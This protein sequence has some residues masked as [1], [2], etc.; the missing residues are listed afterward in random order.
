MIYNYI[1]SQQD[2]SWEGGANSGV[3]DNR[4][5]FSFCEYMN[6]E[7]TIIT[8]S[9]TISL[10]ESSIGVSA[11]NEGVNIRTIVDKFVSAIKSIVKRLME[12]FKKFKDRI[13]RKK[14]STNANVKYKSDEVEKAHPDRALYNSSMPKTIEYKGYSFKVSTFS[15]KI[16]ELVHVLPDTCQRYNAKSSNRGLPLYNTISEN[17][18]KF[19]D[20]TVTDDDIKSYL[21]DN[22]DYEEHD[23]VF[24]VKEEFD[25][26]SNKKYSVN[27]MDGFC[28]DIANYCS[29]E[30]KII[31]NIAD[32]TNM[33]SGRDKTSYN[34]IQTLINE[35]IK[36][37]V[38]CVKISEI[39]MQLFIRRMTTAENIVSIVLNKQYE[40]KE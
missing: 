3:S 6:Y 27:M 40:N 31:K 26:V 7:N 24:D 33:E 23:A 15:H 10:L 2:N 13:L 18:F 20:R 17:L 19:N 34:L 1:E 30:I 38:L 36:A 5:F 25:F 9:L 11:L 4:D 22:G 39:A 35:Y 37:D 8:N 16:S 28:E 14:K 29:N 21:T 32:E 12:A